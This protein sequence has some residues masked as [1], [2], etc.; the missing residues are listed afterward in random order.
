MDRSSHASFSHMSKINRIHGGEGD[1]RWIDVLREVSQ[2][3]HAMVKL[4]YSLGLDIT[5]FE[6]SPSFVY[7]VVRADLPLLFLLEA[8]N[9]MFF[10]GGI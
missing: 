4:G 1:I 3:A 2:V 10:V 8:I 6:F 5:I 9:T 7:N